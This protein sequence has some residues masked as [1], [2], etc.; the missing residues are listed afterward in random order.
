MRRA[1]GLVLVGLCLG[2]AL[3]PGH[4]NH[5]NV[6]HAVY[7]TTVHRMHHGTGYYPAMDRALRR[8]I[9]PA[10]TSRA[11]RPPTVFLLWSL[12]PGDRWIWLLLVALVGAA[13]WVLLG[14]TDAPWAVP[15]IALYLLYNAW[16]K[17]TLVELWTVP[18]IVGALWAW[19]ADRP[20]VA[21]GVAC[22]AALVRETSAPLLVGGLFAAWRAGRPRWPW[23]TGLAVFAAG[24]ALH[25]HL[26]SPHLSA[27]G[28]ESPLLGT[29]RAPFSVARWMGFGLPAGPVVGPI[30]WGLTVWRLT[31]HRDFGDLMLP[32]MAMP[33][34]GVLI[35][36][37][38][39]GA[40]LVPFTILWG[41]EALQ[42]LARRRIPA[43]P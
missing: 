43:R 17:Y 1:C 25:A 12:L 38:Y 32:S 2:Y 3:T 42:E 24:L 35:T 10:E 4:D 13:G 39:W 29:G 16:N 27:H 33:V 37:D 6:D 41:A 21:A 28:A 36:R 8:Q 19:R 14:L 15:L 18:L 31:H 30:L 5:L 34:L 7:L 23:A 22:A 11:F 26:A 20:T 9:G 40:L